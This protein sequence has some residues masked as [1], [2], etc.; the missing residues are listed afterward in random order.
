MKKVELVNVQQYFTES[1]KVIRIVEEKQNELHR[2]LPVTHR[3][4]LAKDLLEDAKTPEEYQLLKDRIQ[5]FEIELKFDKG[6]VPAIPEEHQ[7]KVA[8][9][10][11]SEEEKLDE[12]LSKQ[13]ELLHKLVT[14]FEGQLTP[15][16]QNVAALERRKLTGKKIDILLDGD[17]HKSNQF[18]D[19]LYYANGLAFSGGEHRAKKANEEFS[20]LL[21]LLKQIATESV[22][23]TGIQKPSIFQRILGG[24]K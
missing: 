23:P 24:K 6:T 17:I 22:E 19:A 20:K 10:R 14:D 2:Q 12:E 11:V 15:T 5:E 13:K 1:D 9:N 8:F 4:Q 18:T 16:L 21:D 7:L 3:L